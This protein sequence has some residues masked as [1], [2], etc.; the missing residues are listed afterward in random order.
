MLHAA[1]RRP[2]GLTLNNLGGSWFVVIVLETFVVL[3]LIRLNAITYTTQASW[4]AEAPA[5]DLRLPG[6]VTNPTGPASVWRD[7]A[8]KAEA[9]YRSVDDN[10]Q[11][12]ETA[13]TKTLSLKK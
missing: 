11:A 4:L 9:P 1:P 12:T 8:I 2:N 3:L 6:Y 13:E 7:Q 10:E 5:G